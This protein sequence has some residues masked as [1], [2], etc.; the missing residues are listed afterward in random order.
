MPWTPEETYFNCV[1][2][3]A[4]LCLMFVVAFELEVEKRLERQKD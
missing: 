1:C 2:M 4:G 3:F